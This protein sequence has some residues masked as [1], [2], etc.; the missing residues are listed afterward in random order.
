M[1]NAQRIN[2]DLERKICTGS[3]I[4]DDLGHEN[5]TRKKSPRSQTTNAT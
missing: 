2:T 4:V 3:K 5:A 1:L